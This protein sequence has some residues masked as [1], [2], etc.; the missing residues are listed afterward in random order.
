MLDRADK[1]LSVRRQCA[2][3]SVARSGVYRSRKPV[4]DNDGA[5]MRRIDELFTAW[6]FLKLAPDD[7]D[8]A[9]RG[10]VRESQAGAAADAPDGDRRTRAEA[11]N[12]QAGARPPD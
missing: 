3:L 11:E 7:G 6:P 4:N 8:A 9:R 12:E 2:L 5:L 1:S 10:G